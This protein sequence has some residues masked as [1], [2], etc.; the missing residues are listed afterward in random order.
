MWCG[1]A[2]LGALVAGLVIARSAGGDL[3][4][5][6]I[7]KRVEAVLKV[8]SLSGVFQMLTTADWAVTSFKVEEKGAAFGFDAKANRPWVATARA[9]HLWDRQASVN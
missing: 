1:A 7:S 5:A 9:V 4:L 2:L 8:T 3:R 6:G